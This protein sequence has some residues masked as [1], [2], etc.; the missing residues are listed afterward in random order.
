MSLYELRPVDGQRVHRDWDTSDYCGR[1]RVSA[2]SEDAARTYAARGFW[3]AV[4]MPPLEQ[5]LATSPWYKPDLVA[6][7]LVVV[8]QNP[9]PPDGMIVMPKE[10]G[11]PDFMAKP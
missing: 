5:E 6:C 3:I 10:A 7:A 11:R 1:C 2:A 8:K 9:T 4:G